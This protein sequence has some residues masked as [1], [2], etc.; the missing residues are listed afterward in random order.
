LYSS[1]APFKQILT[2]YNQIDPEVH[3]QLAISHVALQEQLKQVETQLSAARAEADKVAKLEGE[4]KG[5]REI[6]TSL[7]TEVATSKN[8]AQDLKRRV[9][10]L[11]KNRVDPMAA[12]KLK[13]A[14]EGNSR[15][16]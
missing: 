5:E 16:P 8:V 11:S 14:E 15:F 3:R 6:V 10:E 9:D 1:F 7:R 13:V 2:K 4:L 12:A